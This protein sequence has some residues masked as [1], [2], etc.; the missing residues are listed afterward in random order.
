M[1]YP[2]F[3]DLVGHPAVVIG[4]G[5]VA[6]RKVRTLLA[7]RA[8]V[9]IISPAASGAIRQLARTKR[10]R[11]LRRCYRPGDLRGARLVVAATD[12]LAVNARVCAEA[13]RRGL[14]VNCVA[15][16]AAGNFIVPSLVRRGGVIL[17]ISTGGASPAFAK[18][19]RL[20]LE[21]FLGDSYPALLK[22]MAANRKKRK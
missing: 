10:V 13:K 8:R 5:G 21:R 16:P 20:D 2:L 19:L 11:W 7:A 4:A 14:L 6:T 22:K 17:A 3:L 12:D 1:R 15:P 18:R 9:T